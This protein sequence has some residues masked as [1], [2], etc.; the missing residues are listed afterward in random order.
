[1]WFMASEPTVIVAERLE[2][3]HTKRVLEVVI[4]IGLLILLSVFCFY[5]LRPFLPIILWGIIIAVAIYP[6]HRGITARLGNKGTLAA[7]L[8]TAILLAAVIVPAVLLTGTLVG[9]IHTITADIRDGTLAIPSAPPKLERVPVVGARIAEMWNM[10]STNL[11]AVLQKFAPQLRTVASE[12]LSTS[13]GI[14]LALIQI[15]FSIVV[16][17]VLL[18]NN[19]GAA[20]VSHSLANRLLGN[21]GLEFEQVVGSTIR[22]VTTGI[23]GVALIQTLCASVGFLLVGLPGAGLWGMAFLVLAVLQVGTLLLIPA[24]LYVFVIASTTKAVLFLIWCVF[25]GI[26]DNFLKPILLGRGAAVPTVVVFLGAI[27]GF[28]AMGLIGLFVG[29]VVLSV[30]YKLFLAWLGMPVTIKEIEEH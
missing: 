19:E 5:I 13:A 28:L 9:G 17:G 12:V 27:G 22:S 6:A 4:R 23:I 30:G 15:V 24:V 20:R 16:A 11:T 2:G 29:A 26:M 3:D 7:I 21:R 25:V 18:A 8:I 10:A 14:G 1:V